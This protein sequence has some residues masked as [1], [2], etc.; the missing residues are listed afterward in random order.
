VAGTRGAVKHSWFLYDDRRRFA[1]FALVFAGFAL[2]F[3]GFALVFALFRRG[4]GTF[5]MRTSPARTSAHTRSTLS[6]KSSASTGRIC[7]P[8]T[9]PLASTVIDRRLG[10]SRRSEA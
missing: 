7:H 8:V 1:G 4:L 5:P 6:S 9:P 3:A 10:S 2:V